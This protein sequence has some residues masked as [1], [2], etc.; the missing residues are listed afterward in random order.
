MQNFHAS[1]TRNIKTQ[2]KSIFFGIQFQISKTKRRW[3][4]SI[5]YQM[6]T[7]ENGEPVKSLNTAT[8]VS[9]WFWFEFFFYLNNNGRKTN[10]YE[11][12]AGFPSM[13][14]TR[15]CCDCTGWVTRPIST[16]DHSI[17]SSFIHFTIFLL[18]LLIDR[19]NGE[20]TYVYPFN[21]FQIGI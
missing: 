19:L 20:K 12:A 7:S 3:F 17:G 8:R 21:K 18:I 11:R 2:S 14:R 5:M 6:G 13:W 9:D 10:L 16:T 4:T 15:L 1:P